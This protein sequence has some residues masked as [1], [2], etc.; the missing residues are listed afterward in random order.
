[1][2]LTVETGSGSA[3][4]DSYL[5]VADG[6]T[7]HTAHGNPTAWSGA[8]TATKEEALRMGT[9]YL[10]LVYGQ[11]WL[12]YRKSETQALDWPRAG[13]TDYDGYWIAS[14][15]L[16]QEAKDATAEMALRHISESGGILPDIAEPGII[17]SEEV[18]VGSIKDKKT[19]L[20]GK[21]QVKQFRKVALLVRSI[22]TP[23]GRMERA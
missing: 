20:G 23:Y 4:A 10:D 7:Y 2:A 21:S 15:S 14:T 18:G 6:D 3:S 11:R 9:Q 22:S 12:G 1:M 8:S 5:S 19:Y 17:G 13:G 16:P